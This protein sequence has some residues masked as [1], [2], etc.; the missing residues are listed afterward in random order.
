[1]NCCNSNCNQGRSCP[2]R[3]YRTVL[4][5][6]AGILLAGGGLGVLLGLA[7]MYGGAQ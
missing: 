1:M 4:S 7:F 3:V 6:V 5:A 2:A